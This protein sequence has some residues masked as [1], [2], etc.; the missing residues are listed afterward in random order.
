MKIAGLT[1]TTLLDYPGHVAATVF[2]AGCNFLCPFCHNRDL[3]AGDFCDEKL[4]NEADIIDFLEKRKNVLSGL[5]I[6]GGEPTLQP[7][8]ED[9]IRMVKKLGYLV[10]LDTNGYRPEVIASLIKEGLLD[11]I[12]MDLKNSK[13]KYALA[14]GFKAK[15]LDNLSLEKIEKSVLIIK[16]SGLVHEFRTTVVKELHTEDDLVKI[17]DWLKGSSW[18][19]QPFKDDENVIAGGFSSYSFSEITAICDSLNKKGNA[20]KVRA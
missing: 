4:L 13:E 1:K 11:Y 9:F 17:G 8:L 19:L 14:C 6:S 12:A 15:P 2:T 20:V 7:D 16:E 5:C 18:F 10:K 3:I